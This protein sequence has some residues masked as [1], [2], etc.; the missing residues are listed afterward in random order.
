MNNAV[1]AQLVSDDDRWEAVVRRDASVDGEFYYSVATTGVYC[2][3]G[4]GARP[5]KR[6]NVRFHLSCEAAETLGF[7]PCKRCR[8]NSPALAAQHAR[9]IETACR[10]LEAAD[11]LPNLDELAQTLGMSRFHFQRV[12]KTVA[13]LTPRA[14][15][16]ESQ[17]KR[18]QHELQ[19][20]ATVTDAIYSA[21]FNSNGRFYETSPQRLGMTPT[22]FRSGGEGASIR[23]AVGEC[24]L[25]N[26]LVAATAKGICAILLGNDAESLLHDLEDRFPKAQ[27][28]GGDEDFEQWIAGVIGFVDTPA[29]TFDLPLD[30]QGT[31]FQQRVWQALR[32]IPA[33]KT[34]SYSEVALRLGLPQAARAVAR[35]CASNSIAVA[36]PCHRVVRNDGQLSG[37]RWGVER[38]RALL[39]R[40]ANPS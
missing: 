40:E 12:F 20:T 4:C 1:R 22:A 27:L 16:L 19:R 30:I 32:E 26:I 29:Q 7:R 13:R 35:A 39:E 10:A 11:Q 6:E 5:A 14:Y 24:S 31:A 36:I 17:A 33:G 18:V 21:G 34:A 3:P 15:F 25:G 23:F 38:K 2:R 9:V 37:Y 8:P 28:I